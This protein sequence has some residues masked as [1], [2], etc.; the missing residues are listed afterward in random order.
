M[1]VYDQAA[2]YAATADPDTVIQRLL[3]PSGVRWNFLGW[4]DTR[5]LPLPGGPDRIADLV[6]DLTDGADPPMRWLNILEFQA[7]DAQDKLD[8]TLEVVGIMRYRVRHGDEGQGRYKVLASLI[9]LVGTRQQQRLDMALPDGR[10][11][12]FAPC[13]WTIA[14]DDAVESINAVRS[15]AASWGLLFWVPLMRGADQR[16]TV[17][18][19][20][21]TV[22]ACVQ[23]QRDHSV[24]AGI[25]MPFAILARRGAVWR[26]IL[27]RINVSDCEIV[28]EW[29]SQARLEERLLVQRETLLDALNTRF[30]EATPP[31]TS[32]LIQEQVSSD[33]LKVWL[34]AALRV[35]SF[36]EFLAVVTR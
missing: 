27:A 29:T 16:S 35:S 30:P 22:F 14:E 31:E 21:E 33:V 28:N 10:G 3:A 18:L 6:A 1:G 19:W 23:S 17:E 15:G 34:R 7:Q 9:D 24:L 8:A 2:R 20:L 32:R 13:V 12:V 11:T 36:A 26:P 5:T 25:A 4:L